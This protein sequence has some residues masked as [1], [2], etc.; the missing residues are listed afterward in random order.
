MPQSAWGQAAPAGWAPVDSAIGRAG[1]AADGGVRKYTFPRRDLTVTVG[2]VAVMPALA[3]RSWVAFSGTPANTLLLGDLVLL[4]PEVT[5]V[6][7]TLERQGVHATALHNHLAGE[8]PRVMYLHVHGRGNAVTLARAIRAAWPKPPRPPRC[9]T[10]ADS[11]FAF[12]STPR[13]S[14]PRSA[15]PAGWATVSGRHPCR[16]PS[17]SGSAAPRF[18]RRWASPPRSAF[19]PLG[20]ERAAVAGDFV[21]LPAEVTPVAQALEGG[22]IAVTA[23][24]SHMVDEQPR[25]IFLHFWGTG[26]ADS[27]ARTLRSALLRTHAAATPGPRRP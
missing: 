19:Q 8:S 21:L 27:L 6:I 13:R 2:D 7:A 20:P 25:L 1:S 12:S 5:P 4:E 23:I 26:P 24:H 10:A 18:R 16:G 22:G 14:R 17:S 3:L 11:P 15:D 9:P